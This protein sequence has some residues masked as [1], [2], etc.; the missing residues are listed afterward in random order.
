MRVKIC[1]LTRAEDAAQ[2]QALGAWALGF[3]FYPKSKRYLTP[4]QAQAIIAS[5]QKPAQTIGVF[6][7]QTDEALTIAKQ[8]NLSGM[9]LHGDETPGDCKKVKQDFSGLVI[10][11]LRPATEKDLAVIPAY[12]G[13]VDYILLDAAVSGQWGGTGQVVDWGLAA[14]A[15]ETGIPLILSG[16]LTAENILAA[17]RKVR[18]FALDLS[19]GVEISPGIKDTGKLEQLFKVIHGAGNEN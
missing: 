17:N 6:V 19:S 3:I 8:I 15:A 10:K 9:Q 18:P 12:K 14:K 7:N 5:L 11:A 1:G 4:I 13:T 16:G 2:A